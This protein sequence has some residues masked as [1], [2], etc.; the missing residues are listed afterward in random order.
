[1]Q[2][3]IC[4]PCRTSSVTWQSLPARGCQP[5]GFYSCCVSLLTPF[6]AMA[7]ISVMQDPTSDMAVIAPP[8]LFCVLPALEQDPT[9]DMAVIARKGSDLVKQVREKKEQGKSRQRFWEL[10]GRWQLQSWLGLEGRWRGRRRSRARA[11]SSSGSWQ[12]GGICC[13]GT[14]GR[15]GSREQQW[16]N[17]EGEEGGGAGQEQAALL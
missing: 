12:V 10:A 4:L 11:G 16:R 2:Y 8:H 15:E 5:L 7:F 14:V 17:G 6:N 9:S 1:M 3:L 13:V